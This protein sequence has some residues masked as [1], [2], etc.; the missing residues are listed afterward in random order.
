L[1]NSQ[2]STLLPQVGKHIPQQLGLSRACTNP[3]ITVCTKLLWH[4]SH[5]CTYSW[6]S[7]KL[8][9]CLSSY[10]WHENASPL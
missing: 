1:Q 7:W 6:N 2:Q 8:P 3:V 9:G 10:K 4:Y 5:A